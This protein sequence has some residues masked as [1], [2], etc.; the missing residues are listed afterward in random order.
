MGRKAKV[1]AAPIME[2]YELLR[3]EG[4]SA[5]TGVNDIAVEATQGARCNARRTTDRHT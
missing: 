1:R 3:M 5:A 4:S 2:P